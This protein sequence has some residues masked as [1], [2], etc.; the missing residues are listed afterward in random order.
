MDKE[1]KK[2][3]E[4]FFY[5]LIDIH[6]TY[7]IMKGISSLLSQFYG[8]KDDPIKGPLLIDALIAIKLKEYLII[9]L[10]ALLVDNNVDHN[11]ISLKVLYDCCNKK[12]AKSLIEKFRNDNKDLLDRINLLRNK[13]FAHYEYVTNDKILQKI[14][15]YRSNIPNIKLENLIKDCE[16]LLNNLSYICYDDFIAPPCLGSMMSSLVEEWLSLRN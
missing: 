7:E 6:D 13:Q 4:L 8:D 11:T 15:F 1:L 12:E 3:S 14:E 10:R 16:H 9:K 2:L 5:K